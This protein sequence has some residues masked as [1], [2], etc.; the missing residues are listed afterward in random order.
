VAGPLFMC[1]TA[2][3]PQMCHSGPSGIAMLM[4]SFG[5]AG[6]WYEFLAP[7]ITSYVVQAQA[8]SS[9]SLEVTFTWARVS[10][11]SLTPN[12]SGYVCQESP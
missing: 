4:A 8:G 3:D 10:Q 6:L 9:P 2:P 5:G 11:C 12:G 7:D 1:L